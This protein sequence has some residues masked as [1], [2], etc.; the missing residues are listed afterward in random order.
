MARQRHHLKAS[1]AKEAT[2]GRYEC[3]AAAATACLFLLS[4]NQGWGLFGMMPLLQLS[5][6]F[7]TNSEGSTTLCYLYSNNYPGLGGGGSN[8]TAVE[9]DGPTG[10][11]FIFYSAWWLY[12][13][14]CNA[15][16]WL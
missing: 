15:T 12:F 10:Q 7:F 16:N 4:C 6:P 11:F 2:N 3:V 8:L 13:S 5:V 14:C 1:Q 9:F